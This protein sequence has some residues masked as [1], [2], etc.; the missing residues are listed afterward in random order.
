VIKAVWA[1]AFGGLDAIVCED[2]P[3]P[4]P[5]PCQVL[6]RVA[7][8]GVGPWDAWVQEGKSVVPQPLS[9]TLGADLSGVIEEV[10]PEVVDFQL[11]EQIFGVTNSRFTGAY[12]EYTPSPTRR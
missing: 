8:A 5:G 10:G 11:G 12:A 4:F 7:A 9:L 3:K 1:H 6:I 2:V